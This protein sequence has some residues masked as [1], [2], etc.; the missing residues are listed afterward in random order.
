MF[1]DVNRMGQNVATT[2]AGPLAATA[3]DIIKLT[4]GNMQ[5]LAQGK[6]TKAAAETLQF[7]KNNSIPNLWYTKQAID[8]LIF[9]RA[10]ESV[11]PGYLSRMQ[12]RVE[13]ENNTSFWW[14]PGDLLPSAPPNLTAIGGK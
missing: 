9:N 11:N 1:G 6:P 8:A 4:A 10:Q 2:L 14:R 7:V 3:T 13:R 12:S 5:E